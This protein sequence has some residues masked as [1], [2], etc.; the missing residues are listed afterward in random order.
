MLLAILSANV[1]VVALLNGYQWQIGPLH[2][3]ARTV[4]KPLLLLDGAVV[5][6][7][8]AGSARTGGDARPLSSAVA[9]SAG[10]RRYLIAIALLTF[11]IYSPSFLINLDHYDWTHKHIS[12]DLASQ[13][14]SVWSLFLQ[15]QADGFY[16]PLTFLTLWLDYTI[17]GDAW[18]GYHIQ[19]VLLH[20]T[21]ALAVARVGRVIGLTEKTCR[22]AAAFFAAAAVN[23]EAVI[24][25]AARFDLLATLFSLLAVER[26][27]AYARGTAGPRNGL[28]VS[29]VCYSAGVLS[30][31]SAYSFPLLLGVCWVTARLFSW[32]P[33]AQP[34]R[35]FRLFSFSAAVTVALVGVRLAVY[36]H[37]GGYPA[38]GP[39]PHF[40]LGPKTFTSL[41]MKVPTL[42]IFGVN[43]TVGY[44]WWMLL[45]FAGLAVSL[46]LGMRRAGPPEQRGSGLTL[47]LALV[48][49]V[50]T[51]NIVGWIGPSLQHARYLY[52]PAAWIA[53][54][55]SSAMLRTPRGAAVMLGLLSVNGLG[56]YY[57][58]WVYQDMLH[59]TRWLSEQVERDCSAGGRGCSVV[60]IDLPADANGVFFFGH[61]LA[62]R[63]RSRLPDARIIVNPAV[64]R[65]DLPGGTLVYAWESSSRT[66]KRLS[67]RPGE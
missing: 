14:R 49:A 34:R 35:L 4:F 59:R 57:N 16:R 33:E 3:A 58:T 64:G 62:T 56:A 17:F 47:A 23:F 45:G 36:G 60:L 55:L 41:L 51:L 48:S 54:F 43:G 5:L 6:S 50:P 44:P 20:L 42:P 32:P 67:G 21:A 29:L 53:L 28:L 30:K 27:L 24:W 63:I 2:L 15:P 19:N 11:L 37:L 1:L 12:A 39:S 40:S 9:R 66:L 31:E 18:W 38:G 25:P 7:V 10:R 13:R 61:E 22:W 46:S 26:G 65:T 8:L 52:Q